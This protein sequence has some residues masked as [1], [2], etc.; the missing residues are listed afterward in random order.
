MY[1]VN[2]KI[3]SKLK[4]FITI[5]YSDRQLLG[6]FCNSDKDFSR[7]RKLPFD[8]LSLFIVKLCK[9]T[10]SVELSHFFKETNN[11]MPCSVSAFTQ[12]RGKLHFSFFY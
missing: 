7:S 3:L 9:K 10:L 5:V 11:S 1:D 12:Q 2:V 8:R 6:K 4:N